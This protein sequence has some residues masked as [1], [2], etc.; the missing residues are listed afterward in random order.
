MLIRWL[1]EGWKVLLAS[2]VG[3]AGHHTRPRFEQ[4]VR[5]V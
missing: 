4:V 1:L 5:D 2:I 3:T